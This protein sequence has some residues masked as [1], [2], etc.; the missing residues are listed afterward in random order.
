VVAREL[1]AARV[2]DYLARQHGG[3]TPQQNPVDPPHTE[4]GADALESMESA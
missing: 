3:R 2:R 4:R 1:T